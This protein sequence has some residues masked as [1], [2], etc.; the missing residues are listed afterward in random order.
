M[1]TRSPRIH[2]AL[3]GELDAEELGRG[4]AEVLA[5]EV[6]AELASRPG[7][8]TLIDEAC[9]A[10]AALLID[11]LADRVAPDDVAPAAAVALAHELAVA[12]VPAET[13]AR[14]YR[15][16][17]E[18]AWT[19]LLDAIERLA[20]REDVSV[21]DTV[22]ATTPVLFSFVERM[23]AVTMAAYDDAV[24]DER[25]S[26]A[27]RRRRLVDGLLDGTVPALNADA[28]RFL[29]YRL[30]GLHLA[31]VLPGPATRVDE[32]VVH[33]IRTELGAPASLVVGER[34]WVRL[35]GPLRAA[36]RAAV[37]RAFADAD[38]TAGI[39]GPERDAAGLRV[40]H[41]AAELAHR[42]QRARGDV[43]VTWA[44]DVAVE[45]LGLAAAPTARRLVATELAPLHDL[46]SRTRETLR[47][48]L[49]TGSNVGAAAR[50]GLHEQTVRN[51]LRLVE[52]RLAGSL[53]ERRT[54]LHVALRL[55]AVLD[56]RNPR[57]DGRTIAQD[58]WHGPPDGP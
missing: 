49:E 21:V 14:S 18:V 29:G 28:E 37:E 11:L 55:A 36:D 57:I 43:G 34:A 39:G 19:T 32:G 56:P 42:V 16:G 12:G 30:T 3:A 51:H 45:T 31:L 47:A 7:I 35:A 15:V 4:L 23:V 38:R 41:E 40:S 54:E 9:H 22:R 52:E 24:D 6:Y 8:R 48:W 5:T 2:A 25:R 53:A 26:L 20:E 10:K 17:Q 13:V 1:S 50:L 46:P 33:R 58:E 44:R 27:R